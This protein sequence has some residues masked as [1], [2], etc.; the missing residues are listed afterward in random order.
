MEFSDCANNRLTVSD[1]GRMFPA[2]ELL[3]LCVLRLGFIQDGDVGVGVFPEAE[4]ILVG[5]ECPDAGGVGISALR[6]V[7]L[8]GVTTGHSEMR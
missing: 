7:R 6:G 2:T 1:V 5:C 3:Q 4:E 8:R